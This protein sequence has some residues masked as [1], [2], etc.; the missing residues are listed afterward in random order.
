MHIDDLSAT[1]NVACS[2]LHKVPVS[3][4]KPE[5]KPNCA[6]ST[7][8]GNYCNIRCAS[9]FDENQSNCERNVICLRKE[10]NNNCFCSAGYEGNACENGKL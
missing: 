3:V 5:S 1:N 9:L 2:V 4:S 7:K 8:T 6:D 10:G